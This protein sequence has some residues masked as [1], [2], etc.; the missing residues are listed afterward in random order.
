MRPLLILSL[1][2]VLFT[3]CNSPSKP[4]TGKEFEGV[5]TYKLTYQNYTDTSYTRYYGDTMRAYYQQGK[6]LEVYNSKINGGL[7]KTL[8]IPEDKKGY[9]SINGSDT[10]QYFDITQS[11]AV[12]GTKSTLTTFETHDTTAVFMG[13]TCKVIKTIFLHDAGDVRYLEY[14]TFVYS[15]DALHMNAAHFKDYEYM[16]FNRTMAQSNAYYLYCE[17]TFQHVGTM[18]YTAVKIESKKLDNSIFNF[19]HTKVKLFS[20]PKKAK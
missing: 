12:A 7:K 6:L 4:F 5:I 14:R 17:Q 18:K 2:A 15:P 13:H 10:L 19:D 20:Y 11:S 8:I 16:A 3:A 1:F 9:M